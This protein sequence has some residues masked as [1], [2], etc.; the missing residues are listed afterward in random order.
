MRALP[1][2]GEINEA[3]SLP[4]NA[5]LPAPSRHAPN[6][7]FRAR[8]RVI[9]F[10]LLRRLYWKVRGWP[11]RRLACAGGVRLSAAP[12][13]PSLAT[14]NPRFTRVRRM[15]LPGLV[16]VHDP[17]RC[18]CPANRRFPSRIEASA[19]AQR[20]LPSDPQVSL[21]VPS[22]VVVPSWWPTSC[23]AECGCES[24]ESYSHTDETLSNSGRPRDG[25][26]NMMHRRSSRCPEADTL[27][28]PDRTNGDDS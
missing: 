13:A 24:C 27:P 25:R 9:P 1:S 18:A 28:P 19:R 14:R 6:A 4:E 5:F 2:A 17:C 26:Q 20:P 10:Q 8:V 23:A 3:G 15:T 7:Q 22:P 21:E 11:S 16:P 12:G